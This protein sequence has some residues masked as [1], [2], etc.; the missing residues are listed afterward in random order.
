MFWTKKSK[1]KKMRYRVVVKG[2]TISKH[3]TKVLATKKA[4]SIGRYAS[5]RKISTVKKYKR[6]R[7]YRR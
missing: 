3:S 1:P 7:S 5:V 6:K 4:K 2:V